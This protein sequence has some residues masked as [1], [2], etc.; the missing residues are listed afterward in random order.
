F[1]REYGT[2]DSGV[3]ALIRGCYQRLG[4]ISFFTSGEKETRAWTVTAGSTGPEAGAA[5]HTDFRDK[6]IR[7][8][9][10]T[11]AD[12][13]AAGSLAKARETGK[14]RTE[15]KEYIVADGDVIEF[16]HS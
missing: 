15:G 6:Y 14:L 11:F 4:L 3:D 2:L 9:V 13:V 8:Q 10:V 16:M 5:I 1:R 12:L 7:A